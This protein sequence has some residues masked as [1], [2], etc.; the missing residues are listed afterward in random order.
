LSRF[1]LRGDLAGPGHLDPFGRLPI[2]QAR[3]NGLAIVT[4][5]SAFDPYPV[6]VIW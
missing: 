3:M 5:D 4:S 2:A 6:W 1:V